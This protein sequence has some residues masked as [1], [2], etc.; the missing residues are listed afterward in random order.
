MFETNRFILL[1]IILIKYILKDQKI[2]KQY[3]ILKTK[4]QV[5]IK[6]PMNTIINISDYF[7]FLFFFLFLV[8]QLFVNIYLSLQILD[9]QI[10]HSYFH[11]NHHRLF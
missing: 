11:E 6:K 10:F 4:Y 2:K 3:S 8:L 1:K 9:I 5:I 7:I